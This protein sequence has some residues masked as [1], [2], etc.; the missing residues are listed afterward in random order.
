MK[1]EIKHL[2]GYLPYELQMCNELH[3]AQFTERGQIYHNSNL[4]SISIEGHL[5]IG[6]RDTSIEIETGN[7]KPALIPLSKCY[8]WSSEMMAIKMDYPDK[9][10][11]ERFAKGKIK[12][13]DLP[14]RIIQICF[15][16]HIDIFGLYPQG[17]AVEKN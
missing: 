9:K 4:K 6:K 2:A 8:S 3:K 15:A 12:L 1:L 11:L 10:K 16:N 7:W 17:L 13:E 5:F 14:Y